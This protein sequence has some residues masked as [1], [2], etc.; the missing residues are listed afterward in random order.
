MLYGMFN[1][2]KSIILLAPILLIGCGA[3]KIKTREEIKEVTTSINRDS[4]VFSDNSIKILD[5]VKYFK[6]NLKA[7][8]IVV[9]NKGIVIYN[10]IIKDTS[11][12]F[13]KDTIISDVLYNQVIT[14]SIYKE[15][16]SV[17]SNKIKRSR[18]YSGIITIFLVVL[19]LTF[20]GKRFKVFK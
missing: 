18:N 20:I 4:I 3:K 5:E 6:R 16:D 2:F 13:K 1:K 8:S 10:P 19:I 14:D 11:S 7:D 17:T 15:S 12:T 9:N